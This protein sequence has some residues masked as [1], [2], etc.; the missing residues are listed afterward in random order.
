ML[1]REYGVT[2]RF[3]YA[4]VIEG[5]EIFEWEMAATIET[6]ARAPDGWIVTG[7]CAYAL[8]WVDSNKSAVKHRWVKLLPDSPGHDQFLFEAVLSYL[9]KSHAQRIGDFLDDSRPTRDEMKADACGW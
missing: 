9:K 8:A 5:F 2:Y 1:L 4:P 7:I 3:C 6:S